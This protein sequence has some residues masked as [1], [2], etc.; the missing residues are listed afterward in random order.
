V[1][2]ADREADAIIIRGLKAAFPDHGILTEESGAGSNVDREYVWVV[3]PLDGT[4]AYAKGTHGFSVMVGLLRHREPYAG[5]VVD[6]MED[7]IYD[8]VR[9]A[10][11]FHEHAGRRERAQVSVRASWA[12]MP[13]IPRGFPSLKPH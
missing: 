12:D 9:G 10:G 13:L 5:V 4:K 11:A 3:D 2:N 6:P 7:M 8:A 1:T